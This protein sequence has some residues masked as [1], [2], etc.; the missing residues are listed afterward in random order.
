LCRSASHFQEVTV[1]RVQ[2]TV[3]I[4]GNR[5]QLPCRF[6]NAHHPN[7]QIHVPDN[8]PPKTK[9]AKSVFMPASGLSH[10]TWGS[11]GVTLLHVS[12]GIRWL[13]DHGNTKMDSLDRCW[14]VYSIRQHCCVSEGI[15]WFRGKD[16][17]ILS[18][19]EPCMGF[20]VYS[21]D[22]TT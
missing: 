4:T 10:R 21:T 22:K 3:N 20:C 18:S 15:A 6:E 11:G 9:A 13:W 12:T 5:S 7:L 2:I 8:N 16:S 19:S 17:S 14:E 1:S